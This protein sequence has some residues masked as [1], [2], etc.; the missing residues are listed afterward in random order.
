[1]GR[2][3][4]NEENLVALR[5][6]HLGMI[7]GVITRMSG[8]SATAK[9]FT[10]TILAGL[11]AISLQADAEELGVIAML[12]A[13]TMSLVD[14]YYMTLE[15]RFR[16]LYS[17]VA[18]RDLDLAADLQISPSIMPGD[19][20][21]AIKSKS[22][23]LFYGPVLFACMLFIWYG[24]VHEPRHERTFRTDDARVEQSAAAKSADARES[25]APA[26]EHSASLKGHNGR[27]PE[28]F[29]GITSAERTVRR[30]PSAERS[31][32]TVDSKDTGSAPR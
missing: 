21:K 22:N 10:I 23:W 9:T 32:R 19:T 2:M 1:M 3:A 18:A 5:V 27:I 28:H 12:A 25:T 11:A 20:W 24:V 13:L 15:V 26:S 30:E 8:F 14:T 7:Q 29:P 17:E 6:A 4:L 16:R 31:G